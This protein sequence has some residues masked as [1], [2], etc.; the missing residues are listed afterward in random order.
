MKSRNFGQTPPIPS[1][2]PGKFFGV[3]LI[4]LISSSLPAFAVYRILSSDS[5]GGDGLAAIANIA[6]TSSSDTGIVDKLYNEY[7]EINPEPSEQIYRAY[8]ELQSLQYRYDQR[9]ANQ[10]EVQPTIYRKN[11]CKAQAYELFYSAVKQL[12]DCNLNPEANCAMLDDETL[13]QMKEKFERDRTTPTS[14]KPEL[15]KG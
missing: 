6:S 5:G 15:E 13:K 3:V 8:I 11:H 2:S 4:M 12:T 14:D 10:C 7:S 9:I 1:T